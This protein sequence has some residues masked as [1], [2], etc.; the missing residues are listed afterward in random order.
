[1]K[2][3]NLLVTF[4]FLLILFGSCSDD[5]SNYVPPPVGAYEN[6]YFITNEGPFQNGSGSI[7]FVDDDGTV[8]QH[9]YAAENSEELGNI[10]NSM[11]LD[12]DKGY[13]VVNNSHKIVVVNRKTMKKLNT[14][15]GDHI[16]NPRYLAVSNGLGFVSNWGDPVDP[17]DDFI[18]VID[19]RTNTLVRSIAVGEGPEN[20]VIEDDKVY[21]CLE[22]G[23]SQNNKVAVL[24]ISQPE[25]VET[26][27]VGDVPNSIVSDDDGNIWVL[28][29]GIP[30]WT[31]NETEG[32]LF[33]IDPS[34]FSTESLDFEM[35]DHPKLLDEDM[36]NLYYNLDGKVYYMEKGGSNI[37]TESMNGLD[38][39]YYAMKVENG[40]LY[41]TDAG[42]YAS[43][44]N[45]KIYTV[46]SGS[47]LETISTGII[48]GDIVFP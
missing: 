12:G 16:N 5:D 46:V 23:H 8:R 17:A 32:A 33:K 1:M 29:E 11:T 30:A 26:I 22:G 37:P 19:L 18:S 25:L 35:G 10:V 2:H 21:V 3:L 38:G 14:I 4:V 28:C 9:V 24:S 6:G 45:L 34:D 36:G 39:D 41:G 13:I 44:G 47:L 42:D 31:Q 40:E 48:P 27:T 7:T 20:M 15:E 43:E